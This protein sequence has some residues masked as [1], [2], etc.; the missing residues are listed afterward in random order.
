MSRPAAQPA[1]TSARSA[2]ATP[3]QH[4]PESSRR[5]TLWPLL[6]TAAGLLGLVATVVTDT[7]AD[8]NGSGVKTVGVRHMA[9]L[10]HEM[11]RIGG[12]LGYL[13]VIALVVLA[14]TWHRRVVRRF[15]GSTGALVVVYGL[16]VSAATLTLAY[17]WKAALGNYL[18]GAM[19]EGTYDDTGL[20]VYYVMNDFSPYIGW[21][22]V[23]IA[24]F[25][26]LYMSFRE[27]LVSRV[28]GGVLAVFSVL[29]LLA[30]VVTGVPGLP[31]ASVLGLIIAGIWLSVGRSAITQAGV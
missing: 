29:P 27:G 3:S 20:F 31:V 22:G 12:V 18:H 17:G 25:G 9:D 14:A 11:F 24:L 26:L 1:A 2:R 19:E 4:G 28:L 21:V 8:A 10:D 13:T 5:F 16:L 7:R 30:V 15:P 6:A 23:M